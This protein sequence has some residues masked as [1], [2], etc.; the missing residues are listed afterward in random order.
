[1]S[2]S[3]LLPWNRLRFALD[4]TRARFARRSAKP[5]SVVI[6]GGGL[7]GLSAANRLINL[8]HKVTVLEAD[9][10]PGGRIKTLRGKF[11][12]GLFGDAGG[13][14]FR[15]DH[16]FVRSYARRLALDITPFYPKSG[17]SVAYIAGLR[18]VRKPGLPVAAKQLPLHLS[19]TQQWIF[20]QEND[21]RTWKFVGGSDA[22]PYSLAR[23][24]GGVLSCNAP[25][26]LIEQDETGV[27]VRFSEG[28]R[29]HTLSA[30]YA[31][32]TVPFSAL[33]QISIQ[34][35]L[36]PM[37]KAVVETLPY[38]SA[39]LTYFEVKKTFL[40]SLNLNGFAVTDTVGEV[41]NLTHGRE[42]EKALIVAYSRDGTASCLAA[43]GAD[44]RIRE[45]ARRLDAI[46]PGFPI[47][48]ESATSFCWN[49]QPWS[50]GAQSSTG[51]FKGDGALIR[52]P[53]GRVHFAGEHT[54]RWQ[55]GWMDGAIESAH[56]TALV[57]HRNIRIAAQRC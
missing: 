16:L 1:M 31:I 38:A 49:E 42:G 56:E 28:R 23:G 32:C 51:H 43:L 35:P 30:D 50:R 13:F 45:T 9:H 19:P 24:L 2:A 48:V 40:A 4:Q 29:R 18:M 20:A 3:A 37:K 27:R 34:P 14:R 52:T 41:W 57:V 36:S 8:G 55:P 26:S 12:N 22:L 6:I 21:Y 25:V 11:E 33:D 7:A 46:F 5:G 15:D 44:E 53:E 54:A 39:C 17:N 10:Q 47:A